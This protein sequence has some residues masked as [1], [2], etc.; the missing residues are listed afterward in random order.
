LIFGIDF[1]GFAF[2][3]V[4]VRLGLSEFSFV[5]EGWLVGFLMIANVNILAFGLFWFN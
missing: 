2:I 3:D 5:K 4:V 1:S